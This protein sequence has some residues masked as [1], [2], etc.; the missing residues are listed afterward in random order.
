M[1]MDPGSHPRVKTVPDAVSFAESLVEMR[2]RHAEPLV[3]S[4][5]CAPPTLRPG[6]ERREGLRAAFHQHALVKTDLRPT[7]HIV[8]ARRPR[9][10]ATVAVGAPHH[11]Q[12]AA[13]HEP[14]AAP[15]RMTC[16]VGDGPKQWADPQ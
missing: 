3:D 12:A 16:L 1:R 6:L 4:A 15:S 10:G 14:Q 8:E 11:A 5:S 7:E 13:T 2:Q 9:R